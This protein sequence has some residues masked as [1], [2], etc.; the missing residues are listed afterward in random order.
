MG[1]GVR[2]RDSV[3]TT[4]R[5]ATDSL[6][7]RLHRH[8][9]F[10]DLFQRRLTLPRYRDLLLGLHG[11]HAPME[12]RLASAMSAC[13]EV[14][15]T[16][17]GRRRAHLLVADLRD[18]GTEEAVLSRVPVCDRLPELRSA[19]HLLG[20]LYVIDGSKLGGRVLYRRLDYLLGTSGRTGRR[21]FGSDAGTSRE[22]LSECCAALETFAAVGGD[23]PTVITAARDTFSAIADWLDRFQLPDHAV[24]SASG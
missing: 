12:A 3:R 18:L 7:E 17:D 10:Q 6:H 2:D 13:D 8:G 5:T 11:F 22:R 20:A 16:M 4:I 15:L 19:A 24:V 1:T 14:A 21:F 23:V 9:F